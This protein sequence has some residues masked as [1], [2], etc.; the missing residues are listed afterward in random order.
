MKKQPYAVTCGDTTTSDYAWDI[1]AAIRV[2]MEMSN[3]KRTPAMVTCEGV[4]FAVIEP[5]GDAK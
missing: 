3:R 2:A 1:S 4:T 5:K